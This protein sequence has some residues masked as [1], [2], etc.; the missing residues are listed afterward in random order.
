MSPW[1]TAIIGATTAIFLVSVWQYHDRQSRRQ[2][3]SRLRATNGQLR[4]QASQRHEAEILKAHVAGPVTGS[5]AEP[6]PTSTPANPPALGTDYRNEGQATPV[7]ALQTLAWAC[8]QGDAA[9][10]EK[11]IVFDVVAREK[12]VRHFASRPAGMPPQWASLEAMAAALYVSDGM[13]NPYPVAEVLQLAKFEPVN[14]TRVVLRLPGANGDGYE[15]QHT[16]EG[17]KL[18]ITEAVVDDFIKNSPPPLPPR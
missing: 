6:A 11:L 12:A 7:N 3:A 5:L 18:A 4:Q 15:F 10:M 17:W 16:A 1:K 2:E 8:D 14:P 13:R 9:L